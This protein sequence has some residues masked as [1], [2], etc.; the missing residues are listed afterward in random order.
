M[1][2]GNPKEI[3]VSLIFPEIDAQAGSGV[4]RAIAAVACRISGILHMKPT[5]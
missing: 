1:R 5:I 3:Y 2:L 4:A